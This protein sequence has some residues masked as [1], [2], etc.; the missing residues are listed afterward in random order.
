MKLSKSLLQA[1]AVA[2]TVTTISSCGKGTVV[3]PKA[4]NGEQQKKVP[5]NCP[6]CGLG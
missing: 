6:G 5:Y 2:V 3:D 4:P 1:I